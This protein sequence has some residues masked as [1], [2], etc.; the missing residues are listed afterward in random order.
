MIEDIARIAASEE[1]VV[2]QA[3]KRYEAASLLAF[4][5]SGGIKKDEPLTDYGNKEEA[6]TAVLELMENGAEFARLHGNFKLT[7]KRKVVIQ[8][9]P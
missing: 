7:K 2:G 5:M 1:E 4:G 9:R 8:T 3:K 6:R